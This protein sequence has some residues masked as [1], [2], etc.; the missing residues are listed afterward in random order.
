MIGASTRD[1]SLSVLQF[2][3]HQRLDIVVVI[4]TI[5]TIN[6]IIIIIVIPKPVI[7]K[8]YNIGDD[9]LTR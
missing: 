5:N 7:C 4:I 9:N 2:Q 6:N 1:A 8:C 3:Q